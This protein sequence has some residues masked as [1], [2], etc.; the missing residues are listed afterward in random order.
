PI[1]ADEKPGVI[2]AQGLEAV[3]SERLQLREVGCDALSALPNLGVLVRVE[4]GHED[5]PPVKL[6]QEIWVGLLPEEASQQ[7]VGDLAHLQDL[8]QFG[9]VQL[10]ALRHKCHL[11]SPSRQARPRCLRR[12]V[13]S[14]RVLSLYPMPRGTAVA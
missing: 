8:D 9:A 7:A 14:V 4:E 13:V 10:C 6:P 1:R 12:S 5:L 11:I 3:V 2:P